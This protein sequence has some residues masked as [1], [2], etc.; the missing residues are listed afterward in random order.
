M[1]ERTPSKISRQFT[2]ILEAS[3]NKLWGAHVRVPKV[4]V[5]DLAGDGS[6]RV[7]CMLKGSVTFQCALVPFGKGIFVIT[8]NR[9]LRQSLGLEIG[10]KLSVSLSKDTSEYGLP[11]PDEF[12]EVVHQD[13]EA[14]TLFHALTR[15]RQR[16]L[17]YIV[18]SA[19]TPDKRIARSIIIAEHL[20]TNRGKI[21]YR[22]LHMMLRNQNRRVSP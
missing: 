14:G 4:I 16:T 21:N 18:G 15:G 11:L 19:K 22:Q 5:K 8:V 2:S 12:R 6:R 17:L 13:P 7:V 3:D 10:T 9:K 1:K 20:K